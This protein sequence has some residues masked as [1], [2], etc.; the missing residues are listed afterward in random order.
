MRRPGGRLL[1]PLDGQCVCLAA[2]FQGAAQLP[3]AAVH[4]AAHDPAGRHLGVQR[5]LQH[6]EGEARLGPEGD[7][8]RDTG[9]LVGSRRRPSAPTKPRRPVPRHASQ[10]KP[11]GGASIWLAR[12]GSQDRPGPRR[13]SP[14]ISR[15]ADWASGV[16]GRIACS[17]YRPAGSGMPAAI[18]GSK[19]SA[20]YPLAPRSR[21][22]PRCSI[23]SASRPRIATRA[24]V[25]V[26]TRASAAPA[27]WRLTP[28][29]MSPQGVT[30]A[31]QR[32]L[33]GRLISTLRIR[34]QRLALDAHNRRART[35]RVAES[36]L[37]MATLR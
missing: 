11:D 36:P 35:T 34:S 37:A 1:R 13:I 28:I 15:R 6:L 29:M 12:S 10:T 8:L 24:P 18:A 19:R 5:P 25:A 22:A 14:C 20:R 27:S 16:P 26:T 2:L 7:R 33:R 21:T 31:C 23:Q 4:R 30:E 9:L 3:V 32:W 17:R